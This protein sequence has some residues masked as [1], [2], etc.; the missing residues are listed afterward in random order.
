RG[1]LGLRLPAEA[2]LLLPDG[3]LRVRLGRSGGGAGGGPAR[4]GRDGA[5]GGGRQGRRLDG[6]QRDGLRRLRLALAAEA[7][8]LLPDRALRVRRRRGS[9]HGLL[10]PDGLRL[11]RLLRLLAEADLL[12]PDRG[13]VVLAHVS[14][15]PAGV[16]R[17]SWWMRAAFRSTG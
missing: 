11:R 10:R 17:C 8:L 9:M 1:S 12:L 4:R 5:R 15:P 14:S 16:R 6:R 7:D 2:D 13:L 3:R